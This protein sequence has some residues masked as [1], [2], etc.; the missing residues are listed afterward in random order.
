MVIVASVFVIKMGSRWF[1]RGAWPRFLT[2]AARK[3]AG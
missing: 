1:I 2:G 3:V